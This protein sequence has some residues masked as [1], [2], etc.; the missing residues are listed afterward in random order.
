MGSGF[1]QSHWCITEIIRQRPKFACKTVSVGHVHCVWVVETTVILFLAGPINEHWKNL[2]K[3]LSSS[4]SVIWCTAFCMTKHQKMLNVLFCKHTV[5]FSGSCRE[6]MHE[7][8]VAVYNNGES[9][10]LAQNWAS[11]WWTAH[12]FT[13]FTCSVVRI[14]ILIYLTAPSKA[15]EHYTCMYL[16]HD[17]KP[18]LLLHVSYTWWIYYAGWACSSTTGMLKFICR[19]CKTF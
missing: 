16:D 12:V 3:V 1:H 5:F 19:R 7:H 18:Q 6:H 10:K 2:L 9:K 14:Q 8:K 17:H 13:L 4:Q 11:L 15:S